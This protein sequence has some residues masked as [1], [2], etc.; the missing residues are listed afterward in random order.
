M[1][2]IIPAPAMSRFQKCRAARNDSANEACA[3]L[4]PKS[5]AS[6]PAALRLPVP[7]PMKIPMPANGTAIAQVC[8][9][10]FP[11]CDHW[12]RISQSQRDGHQGRTPKSQPEELYMSSNPGGSLAWLGVMVACA[13][14]SAVAVAAPTARGS[15]GKRG[16]TTSGDNTCR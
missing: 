15:R 1:A 12:R 6:L 4:V 8:P 10:G 13:Y 3:Q 9:G 2:T 16:P 11:L 7:P 14:T 5:I